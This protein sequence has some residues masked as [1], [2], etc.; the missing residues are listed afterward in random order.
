MKTL[1]VQID[2]A[3]LTADQCRALRTLNEIYYHAATSEEANGVS[4]IENR[5]CRGVDELVTYH[6][7]VDE[8]S[9]TFEGDAFFRED[10]LCGVMDILDD[11]K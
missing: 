5:D 4:R 7:V 3:T 11:Y 8:E 6:V 2:P 1:T 10:F 9:P